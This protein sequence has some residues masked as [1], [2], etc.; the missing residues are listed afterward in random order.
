MHWRIQVGQRI[1]MGVDFIISSRRNV[2]TIYTSLRLFSLGKT[3]EPTTPFIRADAGLSSIAQIDL[4]LDHAL[5]VFCLLQKLAPFWKGNKW[6]LW[7]TSAMPLSDKRQSTRICV[8]YFACLSNVQRFRKGSSDYWLLTLRFLWLYLW[9]LMGQF[10]SWRMY[11]YIYTCVQ[12]CFLVL[13]FYIETEKLVGSFNITLKIQVRT[14]TW[15]GMKIS[16]CH[17]SPSLRSSI[18]L[19]FFYVFRPCQGRTV[20]TVR[21]FRPIIG[22]LELGLSL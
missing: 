9:I 6:L 11:I 3:S 2:H 14:L 18:Q 16:C 4:S 12:K 8:H 1:C 15:I 7:E 21:L 5:I 10:Q 20:T 13:S 17:V 19:C 22:N